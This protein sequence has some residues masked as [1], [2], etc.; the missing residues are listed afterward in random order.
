MA[1]RVCHSP[2]PAQEGLL[3]LPFGSV[4]WEVIGELETWWVLHSSMSTQ[5][6]A[7][8]EEEF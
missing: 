2:L 6:K 1:V 4:G 7:I 5:A 8:L 3:V